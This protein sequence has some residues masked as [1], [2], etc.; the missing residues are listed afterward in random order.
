[1]NNAG[2]TSS[3]PIEE[4]NPQENNLNIDELKVENE[5]LKTELDRLKDEQLPKDIEFNN[6]CDYY[7]KAKEDCDKLTGDNENLK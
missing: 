7:N 4:D 1:M 2:A 5:K 6:L 3:S